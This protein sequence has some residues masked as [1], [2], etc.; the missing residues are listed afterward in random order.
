M[1][2]NAG[3]VNNVKDDIVALC[4]LILQGYLSQ[5]EHIQHFP[6]SWPSNVSH[7]FG[8]V[9]HCRMQF[10]AFPRLDIRIFLK[11]HL[12]TYFI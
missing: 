12:L 7:I 9:K 8:Y 3:D 10:L 4:G 6:R 11:E 1:A 2:Q 5:S